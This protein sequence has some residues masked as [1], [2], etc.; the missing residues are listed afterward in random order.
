VVSET[1]VSC[2]PVPSPGANAFTNTLFIRSVVVLFFSQ[3]LNSLWRLTLI[4]RAWEAWFD[5]K[6]AS[7]SGPEELEDKMLSLVF[8]MRSFFGSR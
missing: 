5:R 2:A 3:A 6:A 8:H 7:V 1:G 4:D